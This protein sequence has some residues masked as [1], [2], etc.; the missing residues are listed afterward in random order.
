MKFCNKVG[1]GNREI[2]G[3]R[4]KKQQLTCNRE[5][6]K[7]WNEEAT[8][9]ICDEST[10]HSY[11]SR[12]KPKRNSIICIM[13]YFVENYNLSRD[14]KSFL[15]HAIDKNFAYCPGDIIRF[16][17]N[18]FKHCNDHLRNTG[19]LG[20]HKKDIESSL[21]ELSNKVGLGNREMRQTGMKKLQ[22]TFVMKILFILTSREKKLPTRE[23]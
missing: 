5:M 23:L 6:R 16:C 3:L 11:F 15:F 8:I 21:L 17:N 4:T 2:V 19:I 9:H 18:A 7:T 13:L 20:L 14:L 22:F 12:I 1:L 10:I